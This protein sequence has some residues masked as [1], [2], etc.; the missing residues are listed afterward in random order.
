MQQGRAGGAARRGAGRPARGGNLFA[1]PPP[2]LAI[3]PRVERLRIQRRQR[4]ATHA[5][6]IL[7][8]QT[9]LRLI[10]EIWANENSPQRVWVILVKRLAIPAMVTGLEADMVS[11][12]QVVGPRASDA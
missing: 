5:L 7:Q 3:V 11:R 8:H 10:S 4:V 12:G 6:I 2:P 1:C 9:Q